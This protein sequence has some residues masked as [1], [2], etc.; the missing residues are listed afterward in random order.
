MT[1]SDRSRRLAGDRLLLPPD[2]TAGDELQAITADASSALD[3]L[4][5]LVR[6]GGW[7]VGLGVGAVRTPL[8]DATRAASG[9]ALIRAREAVETAKRRSPAAVI[10][11]DPDRFPDAATLQAVLDLLLHSR[12][13]R[14]TQGWELSDLV[15]SGL[16]QAEAAGRLGITPQAASKRALAAGTKLDRAG[17]S[18]LVALL[19]ASDTVPSD[20]PEG[21]TST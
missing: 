8:P 7:S 20:E 2:R 16:T 9:S 21:G 15:E 18:A 6:D 10:A 19:A 1:P 3:I 5:E 12:E 13:R 17:R 14:S 11:V 4:L